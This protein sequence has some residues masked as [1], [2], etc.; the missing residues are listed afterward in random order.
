MIGKHEL[1]PSVAMQRQMHLWRFGHFGAPVIVFP[2]A[3]GMAHEWEAHGMV[4]AVGDLIEAG[5][6]KLYCTESNVAE[7]WT[8]KGGD[9]AWRIERH[10]AFERY[11]ARELVPYIREDCRSP[12]IRIASSGTSLGAFYSVNFT[13]KY[14]SLFGYALCLSGNYD[15][16]WLTDGFSDSEIY[17]SNPVAYLPNLEGE[18][19]ERVRRHA[20][21]VLVCGQGAWE[22]GNIESTEQLAD[23][24]EAK[25]IRHER[26][27]WGHD[28]EHAWIWWRRQA[29][30]HLGRAFGG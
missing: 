22:D 3:S 18:E 4:D 25:G 17:F 23:I 6:I 29:R 30:Y 21:L 5:K 8:R 2:S 19:L 27:L 10:K 20:D 26:D 24:L 12:D 7:A 1:I 11:I 13:L 15:A 9:P 14:P 28:V 16:T